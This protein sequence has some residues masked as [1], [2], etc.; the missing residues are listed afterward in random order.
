MAT[1]LIDVELQSPFQNQPIGETGLDLGETSIAKDPFKFGEDVAKIDIGRQF[2][3]LLDKGQEGMIATANALISEGTFTAEELQGLDPNMPAFQS[4]KG[5]IAWYAGIK[6]KIDEKKAKGVREKTSGLLTEGKEK[7]ATTLQYE[8]GGIDFKQTAT[9]LQDIRSAEELKKFLDNKRDGLDGK[10]TSDMTD[11]ELLA[12]KDA[13][14][15]EASEI[16]MV[17]GTLTGRAA[18]GIKA[19]GSTNQKRIANIN[20]ELNRRGVQSRADENLAFRKEK[21]TRIIEENIIKAQEA[22]LKNKAPHISTTNELEELDKA[23]KDLGL[24]EGLDSL[25]PSGVDIPGAGKFGKFFSRF[26]KSNEGVKVK[27]IIE[28]LV[29]KDRHDLFGATLSQGE[30]SAFQALSGTKVFSNQKQLLEYLR[31]IRRVNKT[32]MSVGS[33]RQKA[34]LSNLNEPVPSPKK[35]VRRQATLE[36][37]L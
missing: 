19:I 31:G 2:G 3:Q 23:L 29:A 18:K 35:K 17:E 14:E 1:N 5:Q 8:E 24:K 10:A 6:K 7:E 13:L 12:K 16:A 30:N 26:V 27:G 9:I 21:E 4:E 20:K 33:G 34:A 32:I 37:L 15:Q 25:D 36:D 28:R 11:D 22:F